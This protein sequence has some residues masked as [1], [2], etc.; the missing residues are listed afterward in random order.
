MNK[1][2]CKVI[3]SIIL[4][5]VVIC[6]MA[7]AGK[8]SKDED[9][10]LDQVPAAV[11]A[12]ILKEAQGGEVEEIELED[13]NGEN[14]YEAKVVIDGQEYELKISPDGTL[15]SKEMDD[16]DDDDDEGE[17]EDEDEDDD[18]DDEDEDEDDD[19]DDDEDEDEDEDEDDDEDED[20]D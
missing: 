17:D 9:L 20:E 8:D 19:D 12:T 16:D 13:E 14:L 5:A 18:D 3:A 4:V 11:K 10:S 2:H 6:A 7:Y 15:L 1:K